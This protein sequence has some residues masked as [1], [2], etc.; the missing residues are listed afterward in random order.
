[1]ARQGDRLRQRLLFF[2]GERADERALVLQVFFG[3][4]VDQRLPR[5]SELDQDAAAILW[6]G[7]S[8]S[9]SGHELTVS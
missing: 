8:G 3:D 6:I 1:M 4:L 7:N 5:G 9:A 2:E